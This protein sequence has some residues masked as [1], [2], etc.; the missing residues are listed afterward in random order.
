M[1]HY[2]KV[3]NNIVTQ[4]I[5]AEAEFFDTFVDS[6][7]GKWIQTSYNGNIRKNYATIGGTYDATNEAFIPPKEY[8]SWTLNQTTFL[9]EAPTAK[10]ENDLSYMWNEEGLVWEQVS[11]IE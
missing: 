3:E 11:E 7:P 5:V 6:S 9:W 2:A 8:A 1:A 10:P 4:V